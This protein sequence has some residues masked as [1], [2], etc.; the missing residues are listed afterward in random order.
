M[1]DAVERYSTTVA[2]NQVFISW[3]GDRAKAIALVWK[4]LIEELFDVVDAFVSDS[5]ISPGERGL[6]TI[7]EQLDGTSVGIPIVTRDNVN[8][9][10][11]NFESG[12]LSKQVPNAPVMVMPCLVDYEDPSELIGPLTQFQA[13]LLTKDGVGAIL[14]TIARANSIG[15]QRKKPGFEAR[16]PHYEAQFD[17]HRAPSQDVKAARRTDADMLAEIVNNTRAVR[18]LLASTPQSSKLARQFRR[19]HEANDEAWRF[20]QDHLASG[21]MADVYMDLGANLRLS[22]A[23]STFEIEGIEEFIMQMASKYDV[24]VMASGYLPV[25]PNGEFPRRVQ[26][27]TPEP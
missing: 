4:S 17:Q 6:N 10:W 26:R 19:M 23:P 7:K 8:A 27:E 20:V 9:P 3:S 22:L 21:A 13:K 12:A 1:G 14:E 18:K 2:N 11:I 16:W 25:G 24:S 5:D 15:W